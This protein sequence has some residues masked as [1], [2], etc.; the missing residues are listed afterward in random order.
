MSDYCVACV[1]YSGMLKRCCPYCG[2]CGIVLA[3]VARQ[4]ELDARLAQA[5]LEEDVVVEDSPPPAVTPLQAAASPPAPAHDEPWD[6]LDEQITQS[7][8]EEEWERE[9]SSVAMAIRDYGLQPSICPACDLYDEAEQ[10]ALVH[11]LEEQLLLDMANHWSCFGWLH[12]GFYPQVPCDDLCCTACPSRGAAA[13]AAWE[14]EEEA[15]AQT[16]APASVD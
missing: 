5:A 6:E 7:E 14:A 4:R 15:V 1:D 3:T 16:A 8:R 13:L 12:Q 11:A 9:S 10:F 2:G